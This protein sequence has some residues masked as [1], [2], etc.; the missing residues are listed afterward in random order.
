MKENVKMIT[1]Y[2][3]HCPHCPHCPQCLFN[4]YFRLKMTVFA[5]SD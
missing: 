4:A 5:D 3:N 2:V 1:G